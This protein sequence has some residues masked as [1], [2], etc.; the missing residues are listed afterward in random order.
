MKYLFSL[1]VSSAL[2]LTVVSAQADQTADQNELL[3]VEKEG[4]K[5]I[6]AGDLKALGEFFTTDWKLVGS[7][8]AMM[9]REQLFNAMSAGD[10]LACPRFLIHSL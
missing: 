3:R 6:V 10:T 4:A 8:A 2:L 7:D 5:A 1:F 9:N